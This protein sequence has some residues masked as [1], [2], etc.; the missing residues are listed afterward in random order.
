MKVYS[1]M[2]HLY[3]LPIHNSRIQLYIIIPTLKYY[4]EKKK[5]GRQ[6][7]NKH[8]LI[9]DPD[10][11]VTRTEL[12]NYYDLCVKERRWQYVKIYQK[13]EIKKK[14]ITIKELMASTSDQ[15]EETWITYDI[16]LET[17]LKRNKISEKTW[18]LRH[19]TSIMKDS[20]S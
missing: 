5:K 7:I 15:I 20:D 16:V 6:N 4:W 9:D 1:I 19:W 18:C 8:K 3:H 13:G 17:I 11:W 2:Q 14:W 10:M 12:K